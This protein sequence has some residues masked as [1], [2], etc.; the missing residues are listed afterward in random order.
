[1]NSSWTSQKNQAASLRTDPV[2]LSLVNESANYHHY[3]LNPILLNT[4]SCLIAPFA[5][6]SNNANAAIVNT[7]FFTTLHVFISTHLFANTCLFLFGNCSLMCLWSPH[8]SDDYS[9]AFFML[10]KAFPIQVAKVQR[11]TNTPLAHVLVPD[12]RLDNIHVN[13]VDLLPHNKV[14]PNY[15]QQ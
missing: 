5:C 4:C 9:K 12:R 14:T 13:L 7:I 10:S 2:T 8:H 11:H 15:L 6:S 3:P 1:M